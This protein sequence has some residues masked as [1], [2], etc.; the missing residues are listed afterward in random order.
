M[1]TGMDWI[2]IWLKPELLLW[3]WWTFGFHNNRK[4]LVQLSVYVLWNTKCLRTLFQLNWIRSVEWNGTILMMSRQRLEKEIDGF[5]LLKST[6]RAGKRENKEKNPSRD[7]SNPT[8]NRTRYP[9]N[10]SLQNYTTPAWPYVQWTR[11]NSELG[12]PLQKHAK[13]GG[14]DRE[15][16]AHTEI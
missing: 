16:I 4:F 5:R 15:A 7:T 11:N 8:D 3:C 13:E 6:S 9:L 2:R 10:K 12:W 1:L 14:E